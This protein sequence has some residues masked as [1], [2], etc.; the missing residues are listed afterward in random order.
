MFKVT[1][2]YLKSALSLNSLWESTP[3]LM[4]GAISTIIHLPLCS[5]GLD[6]EGE[7]RHW[8]VD[9]LADRMRQKGIQR[10]VKLKHEL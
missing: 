7:D 5:S 9:V 3:S 10:Y 4:D 6:F 2:Q 1:A 8:F